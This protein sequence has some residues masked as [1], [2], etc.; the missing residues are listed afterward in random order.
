[1]ITIFRDDNWNGSVTK[2]L[3]FV[4]DEHHKV[5]TS[6]IFLL[7]FVTVNNYEHFVTVNN[8]GHFVTFNN[9]EQ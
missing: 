6:V 5:Q 8:Y 2:L 3:S 4:R 7:Q 1:M 9:Y